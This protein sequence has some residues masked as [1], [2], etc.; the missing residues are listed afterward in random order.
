MTQYGLQLG[1]ILQS[2]LLRGA[3]L[4][5]QQQAMQLQQAAA[6][7]AAQDD[8][9]RQQL[10]Q[11]ELADRRRAADQVL[12]SHEASQRVYKALFQ[13]SQP[14]PVAGVDTSVRTGMGPPADDAAV[15]TMAA[16]VDP[17][18]GISPEDLAYAPHDV[19]DLFVKGIA[20]RAAL[21]RDRDN[22]TKQYNFL[23]ADGSS[24]LVHPDVWDRWSLLMVPGLNIDDAPLE[25]RNRAVNKDDQVKMAMI[26][27]LTIPDP[28]PGMVGPQMVDND[29]RVRLIASHPA[30]VKWEYDREMKAR[31]DAQRQAN[32]MALV[33]E[34][35]RGDIE[36]AKA[37]AAG[38]ADPLADNRIQWSINQAQNDV[39]QAAREY[40]AHN[41]DE[42]NTDGRLLPPTPDEIEL[43]ARPDSGWFTSDGAWN[44]AKAKVAA[45]KRYEQAKQALDQVYKQAQQPPAAPAPGG[46]A[47]ATDPQQAQQA[48]P[49]DT[50]ID[51]LIDAAL[52][53]G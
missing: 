24:K 28:Q 13:N 53:G 30:V 19:Q 48:N 33:Q 37:T 14:A 51:A 20:D 17:F 21:Q 4:Y 38:R 15:T 42:K 39:E 23:R 45:W 49:T 3:D 16:P 32:A 31:S 35:A 34:R 2:G 27:A 36:R 25:V 22:A 46:I 29:R 26:D 47:P 43:A 18:A 10:M 50:M 40:K 6:A 9:I 44:R 7:R 12:R 41:Q 1:G 52:Q 11:Q 5:Q 8:A